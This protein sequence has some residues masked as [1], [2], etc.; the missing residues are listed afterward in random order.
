MP[1]VGD[2]D[3][4]DAGLVGFFDGDLHGLGGGDDAEAVVGVDGGGRGGLAED[5]DLGAWVED[6]L[7]VTLY[8]L[9]EEV[10]DAVG[11]YAAEVGGEEDVGGDAGVFSR[12]RTFC[13]RWLR[14]WIEGL[15][16]LRGRCL[17]V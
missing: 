3:H 9:S 6:A 15:L 12:T 10:G 2:G 16:R 14:R 8:V 17:P 13:G 11:V 5:A 1:A 4:A 7:A